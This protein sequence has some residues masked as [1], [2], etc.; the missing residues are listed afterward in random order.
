MMLAGYKYCARYCEENVWYLVQEPA[1]AGVPC[2][3]AIIS[4]REGACLFWGQQRCEAPGLPV[5]WDY[6]VILLARQD[7]WL[8][9]DLDSA[10][11]FPV[12]APTYLNGTFRM[13]HRMPEE[14]RPRFL[15]F[16][17]PEYIAD[18][19]SD[20]SHMRDERGHW[21]APPPDWPPINPECNE[22]FTTFITRR[23]DAG[24]DVSL[25]AMHKRFAG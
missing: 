9:Y 13:Q 12:D 15:L 8:V 10:L 5:W 16:D 19:G 6:H 3:V 25:E 11:P 17:G 21:H 20:R 18:F 14:I 2:A 1:F 4:N 7:T 23:L 22:G 24:I